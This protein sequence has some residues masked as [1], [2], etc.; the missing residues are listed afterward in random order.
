M[1][2][3]LTIFI[4]FHTNYPCLQILINQVKFHKMHSLVLNRIKYL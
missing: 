1:F 4:K 2:Y 3:W